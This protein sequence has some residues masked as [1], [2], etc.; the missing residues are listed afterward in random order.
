MTISPKAAT[1]QVLTS[2]DGERLHAN[3]N[4]LVIKL[5]A[6]DTG[7]AFSLIEYTA[8]AGAPGPPP[9]VHPGFDETFIVLEG[10]LTVSLDDRTSSLSPGA[11]A[12]VPGE[13]PHTFANDGTT[14]V[15]FLLLCAPGGFEEYFRLVADAASDTAGLTEIS[16]RFGLRY[17]A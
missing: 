3:G 2:G 12:F 8:P 11:L 16:T 9:H 6:D 13:I 7:G 17:S 1:A 10:A 5:S 15:R 4:E 14:A